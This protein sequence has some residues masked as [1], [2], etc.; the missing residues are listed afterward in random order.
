LLIF[1]FEYLCST[2]CGTL[3][4]YDKAFDRVT[5]KVCVHLFF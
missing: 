2:T 1:G 3:E 4:Y 5:P